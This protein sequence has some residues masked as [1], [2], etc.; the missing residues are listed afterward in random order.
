MRCIVELESHQFLLAVVFIYVHGVL[1]TCLVF[2]ANKYIKYLNKWSI[3]MQLVPVL[4]FSIINRL[5]CD[6]AIG[7][8]LSIVVLKFRYHSSGCRELR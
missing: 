1:S 4:G 6:V 3:C 5:M 2:V 7:I 8:D